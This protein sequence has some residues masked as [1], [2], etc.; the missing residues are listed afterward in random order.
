M[1]LLQSR[2]WALISFTNLISKGGQTAFQQMN[3]EG[4]TGKKYLNNIL[5]FSGLMEK[6]KKPPK[7]GVGNTRVDFR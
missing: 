3:Q 7:S 1:L 6:G 2:Q 5:N 4:N